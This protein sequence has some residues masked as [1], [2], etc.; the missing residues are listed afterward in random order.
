MTNQHY[1]LIAIGGGSGGLAVAEKAA[2]FGKRVAIIEA[3]RLGGTCVNTG[4]V[5]KKVMWYAAHIAHAIHDAPAFGF[6]LQIDKFDWAQ[7]VN[8]RDAYVKMINDYWDGYVKD[9]QIDVIQGWAKFTGPHELMVNEERR[10]SAE[11]IV[12]AAGGRPFVPD[13]PGAELGITSDDFFAL[14]EQPAKAAVIGSGYIGLE[15]AGMLRAMGSEVCLFAR[16]PRILRNFDSLIGDTVLDNA[17][18]QGIRFH[19]PFELERFVREEGKLAVKARNGIMESGYDSIIWAV[20]RTL[21]TDTLNLQAAEIIQR[22]DGVIPTD[23]YENT[24]VPGIYALGDINGKSALTPVAIAAGRRLAER[25]FNAQ[26]ERH[27]DYTNI[28]SV[29]FS[30]P[31]A[32]S[33]GL[34][35][36]AAREQYKKITRYTTQFTPMRYALCPTGNKTAMK[37]VCAGK[38]ERVVGI[39]M[40]GD[41]VDEMLQGF[42]VAVNAGLTKA[43]FDNTVAIHPTSAEELVTLKAPDPE[44]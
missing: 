16:G 4:C 14:R 10:Y 42:A 40:V 41:G 12:I 15:F 36:T 37:L 8:E 21:N 11:H 33:V 34:S 1:D 3:G 28:P 29:V 6:K 44:H 24:N 20:G 31:P 23:E 13:I 19:M 27:L 17:Q 39:H 35:E 38:E 32:G 43:D 25:L 18:H 30:H 26:P 5:P 7:L 9:L 22:E 2:M